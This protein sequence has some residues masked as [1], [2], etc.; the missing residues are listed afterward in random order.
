M[1]VVVHLLH[2]TLL[3]LHLPPHCLSPVLQSH[4]APPPALVAAYNSGAY[5]SSANGP[6]FSI[7]ALG[8]MLTAWG[9]DGFERQLVRL[10]HELQVRVRVVLE[11]LEEHCADVAE[12]T[13]P[14]AGMFIWVRVRGAHHGLPSTAQWKTLGPSAVWTV[15]VSATTKSCTSHTQGQQ[16]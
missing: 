1:V 14:S 4:R 12:W 7:V 5:V 9:R 16:Q 13:A 8:Q 10:Q 2:V 6:A 3:G 11:A 15:F